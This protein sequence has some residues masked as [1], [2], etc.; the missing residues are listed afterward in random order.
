MKCIYIYRS[1]DL[2]RGEILVNYHFLNY[3]TRTTTPLTNTLLLMYKKM[4]LRECGSN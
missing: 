3:D 1:D 2:I 4:Y